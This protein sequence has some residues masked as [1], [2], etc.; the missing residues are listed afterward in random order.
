MKINA[1]AKFILNILALLLI[2]GIMFYLIKNS[3]SDILAELKETT[4]IVLVGVVFL[5]IAYQFF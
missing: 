3:L 1:K 4:L 2:F 5:G